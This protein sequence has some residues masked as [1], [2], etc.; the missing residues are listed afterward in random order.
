MKLLRLRKQVG[1]VALLYRVG[2]ISITQMGTSLLTTVTQVQFLEWKT[3]FNL[4]NTR[5]LEGK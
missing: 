3:W 2:D 1:L 4:S 5:G